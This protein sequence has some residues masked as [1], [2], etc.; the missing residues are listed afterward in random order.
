MI[1]SCNIVTCRTSGIYIQ[2]KASRPNIIKNKFLFCRSTA[3]K[4]NLDVDANVSWLRSFWNIDPLKRNKPLWFR[5]RDKRQLKF[6][7]WQHNPQ[8]PQDWYSCNR[9]WSQHPVLSKYL[10]QFNWQLWTV[11]NLCIRSIVRARYS[12]QHH[13]EQQE[14]RYQS[15]WRSEG[16]DWRHYQDR[17]KIYPLKAS[18]QKGTGARKQYVLNCENDG[19]R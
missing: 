13:W 6:H 14:S 10:A 2:G 9:Q 19:C 11:W 17:H 4:C 15:R 7:P 1:T 5:H 18:R 3:I 12:R 16:S 8:I